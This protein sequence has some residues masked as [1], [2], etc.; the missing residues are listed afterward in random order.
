MKFK[1]NKTFKQIQ[2]KYKLDVCDFSEDEYIRTIEEGDYHE[3]EGQQRELRYGY[4]INF[5]NRDYTLEEITRIIKRQ[6]H[7]LKSMVK[8]DGDTHLKMLLNYYVNGEKAT[9]R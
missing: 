1:N 9:L 7:K 2:N 5:M 3:I 6:Y 4:D 8:P